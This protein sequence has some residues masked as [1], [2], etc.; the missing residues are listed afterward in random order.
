MSIA[1]SPLAIYVALGV[2]FAWFVQMKT[3]RVHNANWRE[4]MWSSLTCSFLTA[5][6]S[7]P[8]LDTFPQLPQSITLLIGCIV[9]A[10]GLD[11]VLKLFSDL[12]S[13]RFGLNLRG[14]TGLDQT[15]NERPNTSGKQNTKGDQNVNE[16]K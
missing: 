10:I 4:R 3:T 5:S 9:G 15:P 13:L 7:L 1:V 16:S 11:G 2:V 14:A 8:L 12:L 6:I